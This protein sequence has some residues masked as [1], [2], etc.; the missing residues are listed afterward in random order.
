MSGQ[1]NPAAGGASAGLSTGDSPR[2]ANPPLP[3]ALPPLTPPTPSPPPPPPLSPSLFSPLLPPPPPPP[4]SSWTPNERRGQDD[5]PKRKMVSAR[6]P[7]IAEGLIQFGCCADTTVPM[8]PKPTVPTVYRRELAAPS[9]FGAPKHL[10]EP[11][12]VTGRVLGPSA[13]RVARIHQIAPVDSAEAGRAIPI[14]L[15]SYGYLN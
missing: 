7:S 11:N 15:L 10:R 8:R 5:T 12:K 3:F 14:R 9:P 4:P 2:R 1:K 6:L 13:R